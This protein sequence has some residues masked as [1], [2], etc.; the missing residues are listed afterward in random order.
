MIFVAAGTQ[1]G[2]ELAGFLLEQGFQVTAS[3]VSRYGEQLLRQYPGIQVND[4]PLDADGLADYMGRQGVRVFVDASHPY[5]QQVSQNAMAACRR[6]SVPYLRY[7]REATPISYEKAYCVPDY[8]AAAKKASE[9]GRQVFLTTGSRNLQIFAN[10]PALKD[11]VL[12]VRVLPTADVLA[13]CEELGF[14]PK[15]IIAMQ[16]PF[17]QALNEAM[18]EQYGA[19]VIVSKN[20]GQIGG[21][22]TK[23]AAAEAMG[24]P[25]VLID[26]PK[27]N[28]EHLAQS[29]EE[30]LEFVRHINGRI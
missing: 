14:S 5:A 28:Y 2:R 6:L 19:E 16:G 20:S 25:I 23:F 22:D 17:S 27:L 29:F 21:A 8:E 11:C 15:Q 9:L 10:S 1:D 3:V 26:R 18:F 13:M 7:E 4:R 24:L 12:T 30:V